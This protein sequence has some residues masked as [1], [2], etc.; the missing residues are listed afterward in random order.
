MAETRREIGRDDEH[1]QLP[2][3]LA[4]HQVVHK[5][6]ATSGNKQTLASIKGNSCFRINTHLKN[7]FSLLPNFQKVF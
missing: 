3:L 4:L 7:A 5:T 2:G 1:A 6:T